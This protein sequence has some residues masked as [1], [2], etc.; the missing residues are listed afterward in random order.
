ML[1]AVNTVDFWLVEVLTV[2]EETAI[3]IGAPSI[4]TVTTD[5]EDAQLES[6]ETSKVKE[7]S[8]LR[9]T[10]EVNLNVP[11]KQIGMVKVKVHL[12]RLLRTFFPEVRLRLL[13]RTAIQEQMTVTM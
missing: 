5:Q 9:S 13:C 8:P 6:L 10:S 11:V 1:S 2:F 7:H 3:I 4:T 12:L